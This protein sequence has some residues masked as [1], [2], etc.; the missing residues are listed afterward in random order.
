MQSRTPKSERDEYRTPLYLFRYALDLYGRIDVDL[1]AT[2]ENALCGQYFTAADSALELTWH[3]Y[4]VRGWCNPPYSRID[5]WI[6]KARIEADEGF[7]TIMLLPSLNGD[8][9]DATLLHHAAELTFIVGRIGFIRPN[10]QVATGNNRG[11][12]LA[13]FRSRG[14]SVS[15]PRIRYAYRDAIKER[16]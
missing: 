13:S 14:C 15:T 11:S 5:P 16:S 9:R 4:G 8:A 12:C 1:A 2:R 10:G 6:D 3:C 7:E